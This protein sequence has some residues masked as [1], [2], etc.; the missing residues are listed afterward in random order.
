[1]ANTDSNDAVDPVVFFGTG[2]E[3]GIHSEIV[4]RGI[5]P[6]MTDYDVCSRLSPGTCALVGGKRVDACPNL[7][8]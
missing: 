3:Y 1:M 7:E 4:A 8:K 6:C 2:L 5:Q